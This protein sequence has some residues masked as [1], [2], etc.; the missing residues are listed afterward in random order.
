LFFNGKRDW[1]ATVRL[2]SRMCSFLHNKIVRSIEKMRILGFKNYIKAKLEGKRAKA[3]I[4]EQ[5]S[6]E[7]G[8][9]PIKYDGYLMIRGRGKLPY[10]T[11]HFKRSEKYLNLIKGILDEHNIPMILV[12]YPYGIHVGPDQW[13]TGRQYWGFKRGKVYDDY[14]AF[15]ILEDYARRSHIPCI[16]LLPDFLANKDKP[17]FFDIDGHFT[18]VANRIAAKTIAE[19]AEFRTTLDSVSGK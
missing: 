18:P 4:V 11:E 9:D 8:L 14:Y 12:V 15:D 13:G 6:K 17:L 7:K 19:N 10:I 3:L 1:W 2:H 16:N 5:E